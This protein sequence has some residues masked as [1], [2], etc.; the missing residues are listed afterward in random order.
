MKKEITGKTLYLNNRE[1]IILKNTF[2]KNGRGISLL[3]FILEI[4]IRKQN[5]TNTQK[6]LHSFFLFFVD[7]FC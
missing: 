1:S 7:S 4:L 2:A 6:M 3:I 5:Y